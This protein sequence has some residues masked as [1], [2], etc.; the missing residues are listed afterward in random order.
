[1]PNKSL[2]LLTPALLLSACA[3]R[4]VDPNVLLETEDALQLAVRAGAED[5]APLELNEARQLAEQARDLAEQG[6]PEAADR[7]ARRAVL[8]SR[9][10]VVRAEG[11]V[12][13]SD[14]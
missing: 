9:L 11:A 12:A 1:M 8:Q 5:H 13:R 7:L 2:L 14:L 10:A 3:T 6:D 4:D